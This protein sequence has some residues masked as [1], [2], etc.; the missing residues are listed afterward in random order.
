MPPRNVTRGTSS[1]GRTCENLR[2]VAD[3]RLLFV[4][5]GALMRPVALAA[6]RIRGLNRLF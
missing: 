4:L 6:E 1:L 2:H 3:L 5:A